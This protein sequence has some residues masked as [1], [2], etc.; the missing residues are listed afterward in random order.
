MILIDVVISL[1][2]DQPFTLLII[3]YAI[4]V[5]IKVLSNEHQLH[6]SE[7]LSK[8]FSTA[9]GIPGFYRNLRFTIVFRKARR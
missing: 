7:T 2:A 6:H 3:F 8:I 4:E 5:A 9:G 1:L